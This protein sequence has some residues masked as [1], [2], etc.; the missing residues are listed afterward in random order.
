MQ[1]NGLFIGLTTIDIQY[2]VNTFPE[3]NKKVKTEAPDILVGGP[4]TNA[5]VAFSHLN[6]GAFLASPVGINP[7]SSF[8]KSDFSVTKIQHTDIVVNQK[9]NPIIA[10]VVT[11]T[12][13]GDRNIFTHNPNKIQSEIS[14]NNLFTNVK[15][16]ILL[17]DSFY[18]EFSLSCA[19]LAKRNNIT[20]VVDGGSWKPQYN[21]LIKFTDIIIC[22]EDFYPPG[23]YNLHQV[24]NYL[25]TRG[26]DKI[27]ISRGHKNILFQDEQTSGEIK[28]S[29][30]KVT[31]TLGAGD[32]L[33]G[34]FCYFYQKSNDFEGALKEASVVSSF[35]CIHGGTRKWLKLLK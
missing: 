18:P 9:V 35:S 26:I 6:K 17:I 4:A 20:V 23:C 1:F 21:E 11:S 10:S 12:S 25:Q 30:V 16:D 22:S 29:S 2:F 31:D 15:P 28:V 7:F 27:A 5:A 32:F 24:F 33:H 13:N 34:A 8:I 14:V 3:S 19:E